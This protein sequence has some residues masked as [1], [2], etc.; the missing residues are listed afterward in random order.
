MSTINSQR[1]LLA[2]LG[3]KRK[4]GLLLLRPVTAHVGVRKVSVS[5]WFDVHNVNELSKFAGSQNL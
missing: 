4:R 2:A 5:D 1:I 3:H